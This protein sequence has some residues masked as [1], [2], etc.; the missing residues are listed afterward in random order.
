MGLV[1]VVIISSCASTKQLTYFRNIT[2]DTVT[3]IQPQALQTVIDKNDI[4]KVA[5]TTQDEET[6]R[7]LNS[8]NFISES[9]GNNSIGLLSGILVDESGTIQIPLIGTIKA[10][11]LTKNQLAVTIAD[12][13]SSMKFAID[14]I[15]SV[16]I[17][18]YKIT[19]LGEVNKP[20]VIPIPNE[21]V[22]LPQALGFAGDLT[23]YGRRD[24][25]LLIREIGGKRVLK[26]FSLNDDQ[27]FNKDF[28]YLQN[29]D[30]IYVEP[31]KAKAGLSDRTTQLLPIFLS[32]LSLVTLIITTLVHK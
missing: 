6:T 25:V 9:T 4:L 19:V 20:G 30:I 1:F 8:S 5:I 21:E 10:S 28:Y 11:G 18:N 13:L 17:I 24:N 7:L 32:A 22:T 26:R 29:Q 14:P 31:N 27:M 16:R 12:K 2:H 15:V 3:N 23:P